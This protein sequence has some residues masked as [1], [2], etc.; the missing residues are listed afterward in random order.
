MK[1]GR[2]GYPFL[3]H[4]LNNIPVYNPNYINL[5]KEFMYNFENYVHFPSVFI[6]HK[7]M[8]RFK[9]T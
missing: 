3:V 7:N 8:E 6:Y 5:L 9:E 1:G 2:R 4:L